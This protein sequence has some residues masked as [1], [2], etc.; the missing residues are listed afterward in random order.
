MTSDTDSELGA[1]IVDMSASVP[2]LTTLIAHPQPP[3]V[4]AP[5]DVNDIPLTR[6]LLTQAPTDLSERL[7]RSSRRQLRVVMRGVA[8]MIL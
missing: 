8:T 1:V 2:Y 4:R 3:I 6:M 5:K 7:H